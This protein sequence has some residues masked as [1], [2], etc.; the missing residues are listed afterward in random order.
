MRY[1]A[2]VVDYDGTIAHHNKVPPSTIEAMKRLSQSGRKLILCTGREIRYLKPDFPELE[3]FD[4]IVAENGGTLY[5]PKTR[6]EKVLADPPPKEFIDA[7]R[8]HGLDPLSVG[9]VIVAT[10]EPHE[11][12]VLEEI[13]RLGLELHLIFNKG[14]VM[15]L[16]TGVTKASGLAAALRELHISPHNTVGIGDAE[17]DLAF[18]KCCEFSVAVQNA[19][20]A[21]KS[22]VDYVTKKDHG[23]GVEEIILHLLKDDLKSLDVSD[24]HFISIGRDELVQKQTFDR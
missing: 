12:A 10:W 18:L 11:R 9:K 3:I 8:P 20:P 13:H 21:L 17:N 19:L 2:L 5:H 6:E 14:A 4:L 1:L 23:A 16:P 15:V 22:R 24:R 7:L